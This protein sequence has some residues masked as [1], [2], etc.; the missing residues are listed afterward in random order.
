MPLNM[1]RVDN[2]P[3]T[4]LECTPIMNDSFPRGNRRFYY[5]IIII[6]Y[7]SNFDIY[8]IEIETV[9]L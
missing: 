8:F 2:E 3:S 5:N 4:V 7:F 6:Y 1:K 9:S